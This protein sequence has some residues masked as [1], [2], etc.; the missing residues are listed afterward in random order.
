MQQ[1]FNK[2]SINIYG[3]LFLTSLLPSDFLV[4]LVN[5]SPMVS[6]G[7]V[8]VDFEISGACPEEVMCRIV[9]RNPNDCKLLC[10]SHGRRYRYMSMYVV[11]FVILIW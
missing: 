3:M 9:S 6:G 7:N 2:S 10:I 5:N 11:T 8:S 4:S 1:R